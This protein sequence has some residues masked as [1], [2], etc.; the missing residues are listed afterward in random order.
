VATYFVGSG[1]SFAA[2]EIAGI[3]ALLF[4]AD[5]TASAAM[6]E[7]ALKSTAYKYASGAPYQ[8]VGRYTSS[9]D[10]GTGL[11]DA[12]AAALRLGARPR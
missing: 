12:Y 8:Q 6:I 1:T 3:V 5:P 10:K 11:A 9:Y 7:D 4:Q 2:P